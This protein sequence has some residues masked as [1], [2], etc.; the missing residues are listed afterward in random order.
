[1][2]LD[3]EG[4]QE[5]KF[6]AIKSR[7][8]QKLQQVLDKST[9]HIAARW[10]VAA[11]LFVLYAVRVYF[12]NGFYIITYALG[13]YMLHLFIGFLSPQQ[14]F[15]GPILPTKNNEEYKPFIRRLPEFKFW[16]SLVKAVLTSFCLTFFPIFDV[17]VFWP[18]LVIYFFALFFMTM[19]RQ[20][21]H[22][23][24]YKYLPFSFG[25][26]KYK[27]KEPKKEEAK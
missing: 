26:K 24:K 27:G 19:R 3:G 7:Y 1:M 20:I 14:D 25:K 6:D 21:D 12:V 16:W 9:P 4:G 5:G 11:L 13:I 2:D 10:V 15:D 17:P 18:I 22:M 8:N 23:R